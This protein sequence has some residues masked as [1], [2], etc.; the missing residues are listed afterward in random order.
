MGRSA[1][2]ALLGYKYQF[3]K[4]FFEV[5]R[6]DD[7]INIICERFEDIDIEC[8]DYEW[9]IQ[10]KYHETAEKYTLSKIYKPLLEFMRS[11][12]LNSDKKDIKYHLFAHFP[13]KTPEKIGI[14]EDECK[15]ALYS[16]DTRLILWHN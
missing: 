4:T 14:N 8:N 7:G 10:C 6:S 9:R 2:Y 3:L 5:L 13:D 15:K 1:N 16:V 11:Y 12:A